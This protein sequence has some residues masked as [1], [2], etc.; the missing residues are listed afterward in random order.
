MSNQK[1][2]QLSH[3]PSRIPSSGWSIVSESFWIATLLLG[4]TGLK[5]PVL[6]I[7]KKMQV[8]LDNLAG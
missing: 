6:L 7:L 4:N 2:T 1:I 5:L 3:L 8:K